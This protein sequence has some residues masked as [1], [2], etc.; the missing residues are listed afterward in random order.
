M[1]TPFRPPPGMISDDTV[2]AVPGRW[3]NGSLARMYEGGWQV[4]GG[5]E[6]LTLDNLGGV[7]RSV[8]GWTDT[9][10]VQDIAFGLHNGLKVWQG[11]LLSDITPIAPPAAVAL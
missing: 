10:S 8:L 11:G 3:A 7:C 1:M 2:V 4:K 6:R 9:V 5:W